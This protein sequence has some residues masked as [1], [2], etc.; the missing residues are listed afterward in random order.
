MRVRYENIQITKR[1]NHYD[2]TWK[3]L[4][5][6]KGKM[7]LFTSTDETQYELLRAMCPCCMEGGS[8]D[9]YEE[10]DCCVVYEDV[11]CELTKITLFDLIKGEFK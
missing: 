11:W 4:C 6:Y 1:I 10:C 7:Y 5:K 9:E 8:G 2:I 3:G